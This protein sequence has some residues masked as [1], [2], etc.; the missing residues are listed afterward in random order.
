[1]VKLQLFSQETTELIQKMKDDKKIKKVSVKTPKIESPK[2]IYKEFNETG[3]F[4]LNDI[5]INYSMDTNNNVY[6]LVFESEDKNNP[7]SETG[8]K[9]QFFNLGQL[10]NYKDVGEI[11]CDFLDDDL[12]IA[13]KPIFIESK[14]IEKPKKDGWTDSEFKN[15]QEQIEQIKPKEKKKR[16]P[17]KKEQ[18]I[19][20]LKW[21]I[22]KE[23]KELKKLEA[24]DETGWTDLDKSIKG[25]EVNSMLVRNHIIYYTEQMRALREP[26]NPLLNNWKNFIVNLCKERGQEIDKIWFDTSA[27][28]DVDIS[29]RL[30]GHR[31]WSTCVSF[32]FDKGSLRA[33]DSDFGGGTTFLGNFGCGTITTDEE[34]E[35]N[36]RE[37][38]ENVFNKKCEEDY[39]RFWNKE[40]YSKPIENRVIEIDEQG[41]II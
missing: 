35:K 1:M 20:D 37:I 24:Q 4:T 19:S 3:K 25:K 17:K 31:C 36:I 27:P 32:R 7:I 22:E 26:F 38:M 28:Y 11:I 6:H 14:A 12:K 16:E 5:L 9:S 34:I 15:I 23:L 41:W 10:E 29:V 13:V 18:S 21:E 8:Y 30:A 40:D 39:V 33:F 2:E